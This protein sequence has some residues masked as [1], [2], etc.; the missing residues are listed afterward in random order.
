MKKLSDVFGDE[1]I[2]VTINGNM[3]PY[4]NTL[5]KFSLVPTDTMKTIEKKFE[6]A[7]DVFEMARDKFVGKPD[8]EGVSGSTVLPSNKPRVQYIE[9]PPDGVPQKFHKLVNNRLALK[10]VIFPDSFSG[11][12]EGWNAEQAAELLDKYP[13]LTRKEGSTG[14]YWK[15]E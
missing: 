8:L 3:L 14:P 15:L 11:Q 5:V 7:V 13:E 2:E 9:S 6:V 1:K 10:N 4:S 12:G